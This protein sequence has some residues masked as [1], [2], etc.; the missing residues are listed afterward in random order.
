MARRDWMNTWKYYTRPLTTYPWVEKSFDVSNYDVF[1]SMNHGWPL[2]RVSDA[3]GMWKYEKY[4]DTPLV[5]FVPPNALDRFY[6]S[7]TTNPPRGWTLSNPREP[8]ATELD[9]FGTTAISRVEPTNPSM[10][11][12]VALGELVKDGFPAVSGASLLSERAKIARSAGS[13]Y[14][15]V[16]FGW[17][18]LVSEVRS[19]AHAVKNSDRI[20][21][22]YRKDSG[23]QIRRRYALPSTQNITRQEHT[24]VPLLPADAGSAPGF[25]F[26]RIGERMWFSGAFKYHIP[27]SDSQIAKF[28]DWSTKADRILGARITPEDLWNL[29]PWSW[30]ADWFGNTGDVMHNVSALGHDGLVMRY[31]YVMCHTWSDMTVSATYKGHHV[32]RKW[33]WE[34]KHRAKATPYGFGVDPSSFSARQ[35][36]VLAALGLSRT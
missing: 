19:F 25:A 3:G 34:R 11:M 31:G 2:P 26:Q 15:N 29:A 20:F 13:E 17:K 28:Q 9:S 10:D 12:T 30:A 16:E 22:Q 7:V 14:L 35:V 1:F 4:R 5:A 18:P 24:T 23:N 21:N 6:G 32:S 36:A 27:T 8:G 33:L